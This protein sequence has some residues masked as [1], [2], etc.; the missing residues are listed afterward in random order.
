VGKPLKKLIGKRGSRPKNVGNVVTVYGKPSQRDGSDVGE[1]AGKLV[2]GQPRAFKKQADVTIR[3]D[4][5]HTD[6]RMMLEAKGPDGRSA[7][8]IVDQSHD[9]RRE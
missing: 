8:E 9:T 3:V 6:F 7:R 4:A 1:S 2:G 5:H